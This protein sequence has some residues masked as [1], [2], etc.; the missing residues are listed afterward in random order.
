MNYTHGTLLALFD[1]RSPIPSLSPVSFP[2]PRARRYAGLT[3][4]AQLIRGT[5]IVLPRRAA[6][7]ATDCGAPFHVLFL[8]GPHEGECFK[9]TVTF[10]ANPANNLTCPPSYIII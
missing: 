4:K 5:T 3:L 8:S 1:A 2:R 6:T 9:T 10:H 7:R